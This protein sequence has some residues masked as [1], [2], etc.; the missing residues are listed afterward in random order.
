MERQ[1]TLLQQLPARTPNDRVSLWLVRGD[2][3]GETRLRLRQE[4]FSDDVG[5]YTQSQIDLT[6]EQWSLLKSAFGAAAVG[7]PPRRT[8]P[9]AAEPEQAAESCDDLSAAILA[10]PA[11]LAG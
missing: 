5:W 8:V 4:S 9:A 11:S 10:F 6:T 2:F 3:A 7:Q 1:E